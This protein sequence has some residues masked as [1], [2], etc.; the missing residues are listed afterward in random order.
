MFSRIITTENKKSFFLFGPRGTG[1]STWLAQAFPDAI[2]VDLLE[3]GTYTRLLANPGEIER[4]IPA[5]SGPLIVIDEVQK[6]PALL[7]EVHRLIERRRLRFALTG[8]SARKLRR[9]AVNL[10]AGRALT[11]RMHPLTAIEQGEAFAIDRSL[12]YGN[13]PAVFSEPDPAKY[14]ASYVQT[15]LREEVMQEGLTRNMSAFAR[16]LEAASFSHGSQLNI[17]EVAREASV[18]R[19]TVEGY[20]GILEDLLLAIRLPP[21]TKRAKR[22]QVAH[23]KFF[24]FDAGVYRALR[25]KGP[26]DRPEEIAGAALEGLVMQ[27]LR[28]INDYF[29]LGY[30][31]HYWRTAGGLEVDLVLYG[32]RGIHAFEVKHTGRVRE[33]DLKGLRAFLED[34]PTAKAYLLYMGDRP[35]H[36]DGIEV[37]PVRDALPRLPGIL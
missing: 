11:Y 35:E 29:E 2:V 16:F 24:F 6:I 32:E 14:L 15:Y 23:S 18:E 3:A 28:A 12:L 30:S 9:G 17:S 37:V 1:K 22:K 26:L 20:F 36:V 31:L 13:L 7:D 33:G 5:K 4:L 10:L 21:F 27:E 19:K 25:P 8:S 34:Y